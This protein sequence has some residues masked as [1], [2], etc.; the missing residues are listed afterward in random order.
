M[1]CVLDVE[2]AITGYEGSTQV[3]SLIPAFESLNITTILPGLNT[4]LLSSGALESV[5]ITAI[6][7]VLQVLIS[8]S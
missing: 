7:L 6:F 2:I 3:E 5:S 8:F 1:N 4:S